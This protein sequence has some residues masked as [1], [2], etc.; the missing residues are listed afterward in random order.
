MVQNM[1]NLER[2]FLLMKCYIMYFVFMEWSTLFRITR[3]TWTLFFSIV[4]YV[5][6]YQDLLVYTVSLLYV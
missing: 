4:T 3:I 6:T 1:G 5:N 2:I